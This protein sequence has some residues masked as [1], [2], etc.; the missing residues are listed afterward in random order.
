MHTHV[1]PELLY[2]EEISGCHVVE[3]KEYQ[4]S[5]GDLI[6][7]PPATYHSIRLQ[8]GSTYKR[9]NICFSPE[10]LAN[11]DTRKIYQ[12]IKVINCTGNSV[13]SGIF[14]KFDYYADILEE[15]KFI[16]M[17]QMLIREIFYNLSVYDGT[18]DIDPSFLSPMLSQA[19]DYINKHLYD[20]ESVT[21]ISSSLFI[22]DS[23]LYEIFK[24]QLKT[25]PKK[26]INSK[27]LHAARREIILGARPSDACNTV[28]FHDYAAFYRSYNRFFGHSPSQEKNFG[29]SYEKY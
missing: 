8:P 28:G 9:Y 7:V 4:L 27:R 14:R 18:L 26:Y 25:S 1:V 17:T 10:I 19:I 6:I 3:D 2:I 16:D 15:E 23:Y 29:W 21:E 22:T 20:I 24:N 11:I 13:I 12:N 5:G